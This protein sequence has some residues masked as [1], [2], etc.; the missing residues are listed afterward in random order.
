MTKNPRYNMKYYKKIVGGLLKFQ[1][2]MKILAED[3]NGQKLADCQITHL[4]DDKLIFDNFLVQKV[5]N[6]DGGDLMSTQVWK[7][8]NKP[9][10][11]VKQYWHE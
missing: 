8:K 3:S 10:Y 9:I 11:C 2:L 1:P 7:L 4:N 5:F 6:W